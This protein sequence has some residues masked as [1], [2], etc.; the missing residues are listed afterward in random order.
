MRWLLTTPAGIDRAHVRRDIE[1]L[2]AT[3]LDEPPTPLGD[4]QVFPA[5]GPRDLP[6]RLR[7]R[8]T[9]VL[10]IY[11]DSEAEPYGRGRPG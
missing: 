3:V 1:A 4:E 5:E 6:E 9:C 10:G 2:G 8:D 11:P 7:G